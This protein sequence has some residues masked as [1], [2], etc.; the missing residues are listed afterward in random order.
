MSD[1]VD[2]TLPIREKAASFEEVVGGTSCNQSS[3]KTKRGSFLFIGPGAKGVGYKAMFKL[4]DSLPQ[5]EA[6]LAL[7]QKPHLIQFLLNS[8]GRDY[9][10]IIHDHRSIQLTFYCPYALQYERLYEY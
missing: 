10:L 5:A 3:F 2:V 1:S 4:R 8:H 6:L 9:N 7:K